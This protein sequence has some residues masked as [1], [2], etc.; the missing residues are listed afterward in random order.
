MG[1]T[2]D[3]DYPEEER[4]KPAPKTPDEFRDHIIEGLATLHV[5]QRYIH[6]QLKQMNGTQMNLLARMN[7][8]EI[9]QETHPLTCPVESRVETLEKGALAIS[10]EKATDL[11]WYKAIK[12]F[13]LL[14]AGLTA[15]ALGTVLLTHIDSWIS[16][17]KK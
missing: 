9:S 7:N 16:L 2:L 3:D 12:P 11:K 1:N 4:R 8:V 10:V 14:L 13:V 17:V 6:Q 15:G 5:G